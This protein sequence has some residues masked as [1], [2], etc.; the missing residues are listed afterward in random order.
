MAV[1]VI[2]RYNNLF[3]RIKKATVED[4]SELFYDVRNF[5]A[6]CKEIDSVSAR[7]IVDKYVE[8]FQ[9]MLD[10]NTAAYNKKNEKLNEAKNEHYR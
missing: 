3:N 10:D 4:A 7:R 8:K 9:Q 6:E 1:N 5:Y 2:S